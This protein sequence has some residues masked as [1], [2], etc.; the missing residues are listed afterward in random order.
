[1]SVEANPLESCDR[2]L[3]DALKDFENADTNPGLANLTRAV[4]ELC[5]WAYEVDK[6]LKA[7]DGH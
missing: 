7:S 4:Q 3:A 1:M 6:K 2:Y 5:G